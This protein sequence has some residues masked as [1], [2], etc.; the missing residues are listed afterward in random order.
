MIKFSN[1]KKSIWTLNCFLFLF[2]FSR[3]FIKTAHDIEKHIDVVKNQI[4]DKGTHLFASSIQQSIHLFYS[5]DQTAP[6]GNVILGSM[7]E[8][9]DVKVKEIWPSRVDDR[10]I[11]VFVLTEGIFHIS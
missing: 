8:H 5:T 6:S 1:C 2:I 9:H 3:I 10:F 11:N 4:W 7:D